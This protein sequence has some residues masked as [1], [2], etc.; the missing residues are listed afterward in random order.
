MVSEI[1][2]S[3]PSLSGFFWFSIFCLIVSNIKCSGEFEDIS[4]SLG[5]FVLANFFILHKYKSYLL[6]INHQ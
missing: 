1:N 6:L 5:S 4:S 2:F 3:I